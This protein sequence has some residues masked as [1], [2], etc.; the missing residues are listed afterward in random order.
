M[1]SCISRSATDVADGAQ[2]SQDR[3][4]CDT[5][6]AG[7]GDIGAADY[8]LGRPPAGLKVTR[9]PRRLGREEI[10]QL[11]SSGIDIR[12]ADHRLRTAI[13]GPV[14]GGSS[15]RTSDVRAR[16]ARCARRVDGR[17]QSL[18]AGQRRDI[19]QLTTVSGTT[20]AA[21]A[22]ASVPISTFVASSADRQCPARP[23]DC[24]FHV[25]HESG[26]TVHGRVG[27]CA[28]ESADVPAPLAE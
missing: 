21:E 4:V 12:R 5:L 6:F 9:N 28:G 8:I 20:P 18:A 11:A 24:Q 3:E 16:A 13:G 27:L 26:V 14:G 10:Y 1:V 7:S 19:C 15:W 23:M 17:A 2:W 22:S 25:G